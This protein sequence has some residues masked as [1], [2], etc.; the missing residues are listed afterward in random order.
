MSLLTICQNVA[1]AVPT[2]KP[3]TI[4]GNPEQTAVV[5]LSAAR[6]AGQSISR[7]RNSNGGWLILQKEHTFSTVASTVDYSLPSDFQRLL[8]DTLWDRTNYWELRGP[9]S[10]GDWQMYKS[11]VLGNSVSP[12]KRYRIRA[13]SGSKVF[14]IDPTPS[15]A[16]SMVF[17]YVSDQWCQ[18]SGGTGQSTWAADTDTGLIDE[19]LIELDTLWRVLKRL[20]MSY[21][22][23]K[24]EAEREI[25]KALA[26]DGGSS[27]ISLN[28]TT[29][30]HLL[31]TSNVPDSGYGV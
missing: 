1:E 7:A 19:Y 3:A 5:L 31:D 11:S 14:S 2:A 17:E 8:Q 12:R 27:R 20:G 26:A 30:V 4:I 9:M 18:S 23:E 29:G 25:A 28:G 24:D 21:I 10:P 6:K 15:S 22:E 13:S 16:D